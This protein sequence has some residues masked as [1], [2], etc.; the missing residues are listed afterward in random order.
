MG[1]EL[2]DGSLR[3]ILRVTT[4]TPD[5][6]QQFRNRVSLADA[7]VEDDYDRNIQVADLNAW[8]AALAVVRWRS[9]TAFTLT[10]RKGT[11]QHL[12]HR[13]QSPDERRPSMRMTR[14]MHEF[15]DFIPDKLEDGVLYVCIQFATVVHR[16]CCG[17]GREVVTPLSPTDWTL[18]FD[19]R[20]ISLDP[21]IGN[22]SFSCQSHYWIRRNRVIWDRRW[23]K[24]EIDEVRAH[25]GKHPRIEGALSSIGKGNRCAKCG[26][27]AGMR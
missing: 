26:R 11:P 21:S 2:I 24:E 1:V 7:V 4:S 22:W 12:H 25:A 16:C 3:G 23:S 10:L 8:N 17:C 13:L 15:V 9:Y 14:L 19:G 27:W 20:S 5:Q 18:I 6:R